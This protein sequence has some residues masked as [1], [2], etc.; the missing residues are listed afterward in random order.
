MAESLPRRLQRAANRLLNPLGL[1]L[2]RRERVF[3]M[4]GVLQRAAARGANIATWIDVGAS[5]GSWSIRA[6]HYFPNARFL[7]FEPL[8]ERQEELMSLHRERRF[9]IVPAVA[10]PARGTIA[11]TIDSNLD[12]SGVA[13]PDAP[14][15]RSVPVE[16]IDEVVATR[17]LPPRYGLK[18]DTHGFELSVLEGADRVLRAAEL[19]II[20]AYNFELCPG[21]L[22]FHEL[23]T[24]LEKRG[25]RCCDLADAMR[26]P[27]DGT[28]WQVDLV[29]APANSRAFRS[30]GYA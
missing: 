9:E 22:R 29:F 23:C 21:C 1:H 10:G 16:S 2:A 27:S 14:G 5:D 30:S 6:Q 17:Q 13:A 7:L 11:F 25:F 20:E 28:L 8:A 12:G 18:L 24:Y 26:R 3:D 19:L 15:T 4:D